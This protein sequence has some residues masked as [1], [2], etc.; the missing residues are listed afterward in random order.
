MNLAKCT[1]QFLFS[2]SEK[3]NFAN[4]L[5]MVY[6]FIYSNVFLLAKFRNSGIFFNVIF[7]CDVFSLLTVSC[8][9]W[10]CQNGEACLGNLCRAYLLSKQ[11]YRFIFFLS[12]LL[13]ILKLLVF[14]F[15]SSIELKAAIFYLF[16]VLSWVACVF[17]TENRRPGTYWRPRLHCPQELL[18]Q[19]GNALTSVFS[20]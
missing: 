18:W 2:I 3:R 7:D 10:V 12:F 17:R 4:F 8:F 6:L 1:H 16:L 11:S 15:S 19:S 9:A 20:T 14:H 5:Y 13:W